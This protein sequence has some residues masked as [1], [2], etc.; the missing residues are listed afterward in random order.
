MSYEGCL[1]IAI[2][3]LISG[4]CW[5]DAAAA[6]RSAAKLRRHSTPQWLVVPLACT[7]LRRASV[8]FPTQPDV[9]FMH[10]NDFA[11][12]A[13]RDPCPWAPTHARAPMSRILYRRHPRRH[14]TTS[15]MPTWLSIA[16]LKWPDA[17]SPKQQRY[18]GMEPEMLI[19]GMADRRSRWSALDKAPGPEWIACSS[20]HDSPHQG[21][22]RLV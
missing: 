11:P 19:P 1:A 18:G 9:D 16:G 21:A 17:K 15:T 20:S 22:I 12:R 6:P 14:R 4:M 10:G 8:S 13:G 7:L 2:A 5:R 3:G